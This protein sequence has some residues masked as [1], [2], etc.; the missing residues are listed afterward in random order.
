MNEFLTGQEENLLRARKIQYRIVLAIQN[1]EN[2]PGRRKT[3]NLDCF[4]YR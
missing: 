2:E 3:E 1:E 4:Y